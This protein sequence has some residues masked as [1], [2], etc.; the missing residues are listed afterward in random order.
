MKIEEWRS[1]RSELTGFGSFFSFFSPMR[2]FGVFPQ[3]LLKLRTVELPGGNRQNNV[4]LFINASLY[5]AAVE[6]KENLH[7][8][9]PH[10]FVAVHERMIRHK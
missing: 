3:P 1:E 4:L 5:L 10:T 8:S 9:M 2:H 6:N 7:C